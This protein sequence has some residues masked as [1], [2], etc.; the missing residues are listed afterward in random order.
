MSK[1]KSKMP[2]LSNLLKICGNK[3]S[4][5]SGGPGPY[6]NIPF[7]Y[8]YLYRG[9]PEA[10]KDLSQ[11]KPKIF[12]GLDP[13]KTGAMGVVDD[14]GN[15]AVI[16]YE[17]AETW[18]TLLFQLGALH[19]AGE[20]F[21][22]AYVEKLDIK[23]GFHAKASSSMVR[24]NGIWVG[25]LV[26]TDIPF[27][28]VL[29]QE[30]QKHHGLRH[31]DLEILYGVQWKSIHNDKRTKLRKSAHRAKAKELLPHMSYCIERV[32]DHDRADA[33]LMALKARDDMHFF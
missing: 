29:P 12:I 3:I 1:A 26:M 10:P 30:W 11:T 2:R 20:I 31:T 19:A 8:I 18:R 14:R 4:E 6:I 17:D 5:N 22:T 23:T 32:K 16:D 27:C 33:L 28:E 25:A 21:A 9:A 7:G 24:T 15:A 13:G